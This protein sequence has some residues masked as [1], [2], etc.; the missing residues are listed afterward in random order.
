MP[1]HLVPAAVR[2]FPDARSTATCLAIAGLPSL[3]RVSAVIDAAVLSGACWLKSVS[4]V[5]GWS[6]FPA[7]PASD[8]YPLIA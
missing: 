3:S 6:F 5:T 8:D 7:P 2:R 4:D 1:A